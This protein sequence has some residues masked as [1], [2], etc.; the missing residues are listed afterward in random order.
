MFASVLLLS[1]YVGRGKCTQK[2]AGI[3]HQNDIIE[4]D[5][6]RIGTMNLETGTYALFVH[7]E[8]WRVAQKIWLG[9]PDP[10]KC[11]DPSVFASALEG[12]FYSL[13]FMNLLF[14]CIHFYSLSIAYRISQG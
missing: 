3:K 2:G 12:T 9:L 10:A 5:S 7:K 14:T 4:K 11:H 6:I 1:V 13:L 8:C